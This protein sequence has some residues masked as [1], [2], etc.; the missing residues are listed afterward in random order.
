MASG[1]P[2][3]ITLAMRIP[4]VLFLC[5]LHCV[6]LAALRETSPT[7]AS[8]PTSCHVYAQGGGKCGVAVDDDGSIYDDTRDVIRSFLDCMTKKNKTFKDDDLLFHIQGW[9]WHS[10]SLI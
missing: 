4:I 3:S 2:A 9:R 8:P 5:L 1:E 6:I 7:S 10:M